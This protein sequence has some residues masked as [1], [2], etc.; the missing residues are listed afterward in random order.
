MTINNQSLGSNVPFKEKLKAVY[1]LLRVELP[2]AGG[3]C[4]VAGQI[5]VLQGL[6]SIV[7]GILGFL[8]GFFIA[9]AAMVTNDYFDIEVDRINHPQRPLPSGRISINEILILTG[10]F[11]FAGFITAAI[12]GLVTLIFAVLVWIIAISYNWKFKENGLWGN[13]MVGF[14]VLH[15]SFL[16]VHLL[17]D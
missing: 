2:I 3:I 12:L 13:M 7:I 5:I 16:A 6:P 9:G 8:T 4:I 15:F 10:L 1:E 11:T 14:S 17:V